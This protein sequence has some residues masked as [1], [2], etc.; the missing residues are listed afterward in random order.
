MH[1]LLVA[2]ALWNIFGGGQK[3]DGNGQYASYSWKRS[4]KLFLELLHLTLFSYIT[5]NI[6]RIKRRYNQ[7][8]TF[9]TLCLTNGPHFLYHL[10]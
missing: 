7:S 9:E 10:Q 1:N 4:H 6:L 2:D 3:A 8:R 5:I